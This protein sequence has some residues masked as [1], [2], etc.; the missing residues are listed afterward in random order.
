M[1]ITLT[2]K[3][4]ERQHVISSIT[5]VSLLCSSI[6]ERHINLSRQSVYKLN[7]SYHLNGHSSNMC[8]DMLFC[9]LNYFFLIR[10]SLFVCFITAWKLNNARLYHKSLASP[11]KQPSVHTPVSVSHLSQQSLASPI[12]QPSVHTP[13]S[14]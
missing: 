10:T 3:R 6:L 4:F 5:F 2:N 13:V 11:I 8:N 1:H 12:L 9:L 7:S 14:V